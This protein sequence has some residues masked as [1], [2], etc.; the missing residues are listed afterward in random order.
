MTSQ[1]VKDTSNATTTVPVTAP[2]V[3]S[4]VNAPTTVAQGE[5]ATDRPQPVLP[6]TPKSPDPRSPAT[7]VTNL[8][9]EA[10]L[11]ARSVPVHQDIAVVE[12]LLTSMKDMLGTLG[13][14]FDTLGEQT[15][16]V[17][18]LPAAI[19]AVHQVSVAVMP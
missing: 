18:T 7:G 8:T 15:I 1:Q 14:T 6:I 16:K 12:E 9:A 4:H 3:D 17:A 5:D 13:S 2:T 19:D 10:L 11:P